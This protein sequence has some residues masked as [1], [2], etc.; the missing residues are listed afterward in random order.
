MVDTIL[1]EKSGHV[2]IIT[3]NRP[4]ALNAITVEMVEAFSRALS[5]AAADDVPDSLR[6]DDWLP[7]PPGLGE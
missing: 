7:P 3:M 1:Y 4:E 6:G 5:T 2:A